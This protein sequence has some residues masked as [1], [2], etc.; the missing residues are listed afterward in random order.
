MKQ[1]L[2]ALLL[3]LACTACTTSVA[4]TPL[5]SKIKNLVEQTKKDMI[6]VKG[7]NFLFGDAGGDFEGKHWKVNE[8]M[9]MYAAHSVRLSDYYLQS[10][11]VALHEFDV[12]CEDTNRT[13]L[14]AHLLGRKD[15]RFPKEA[16]GAR[17]WQEAKDYCLWLGE[18]TQLNYD[19]PTEAQWEYAARSR[20][21]AVFFAT[22]DGS[23]QKGINVPKDN[24]LIMRFKPSPMGFYDMTGNASEWTDDWYTADYEELPSL[25]PSGAK[26]GDMKVTKGG[27]AYYGIVTNTTYNRLPTPTNARSVAFRCV[28]NP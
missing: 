27:G 28:Q 11:E 26:S 6:Y 15:T 3:I 13:L 23:Y 24:G 9:P 21:K 17:D 10:H 12:F 16:A 8:A 7:G 5:Q 22:N 19:L 4:Q 14:Y 20:G 1:N 25:D 18:K 2:L